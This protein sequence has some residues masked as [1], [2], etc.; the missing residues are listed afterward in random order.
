MKN[1]IIKGTTLTLFISL[2]IGFIIYKTNL[3]STSKNVDLNS[4]TN[5][6]DSITNTDS[7]SHK[8]F[9]PSSKVIIN[10]EFWA[11]IKDSIKID[12]IQ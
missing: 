12:S 6:K 4:S 3:S 7:L 10:E 1:R 2:I 8:V 11:K 9:L 5:K